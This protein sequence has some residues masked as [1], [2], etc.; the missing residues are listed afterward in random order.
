VAARRGDPY[1][2]RQI[3]LNLAANAVKFTERGSV[4][5]TVGGTADRLVIRIA[6]TGIGM[7]PSS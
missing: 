7:S 5:V 4:T 3:V 2:L 6:D 1:R